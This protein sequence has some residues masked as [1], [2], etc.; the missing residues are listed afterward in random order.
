MVESFDDIDI[1]MHVL[2]NDQRRYEDW[3]RHCRTK[4]LFA[5]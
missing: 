2:D 1:H 4:H 5:D 3:I